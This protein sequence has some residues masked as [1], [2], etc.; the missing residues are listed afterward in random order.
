MS[1]RIGRRLTTAMVIAA[2]MIKMHAMA[3]M[4]VKALFFHRDI[5]IGRLGM[6]H[7]LSITS[8]SRDF[9]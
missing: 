7:R 1:A 8:I 9:L 6:M 4:S 2:A 5:T 3:S